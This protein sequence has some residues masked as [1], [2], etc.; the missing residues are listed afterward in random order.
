MEYHIALP[1][2]LGLSSADFVTAWNEAPACRAVAEA[3]LT[4]P[5]GAQFDQALLDMAV[6]V[7]SNV[8]IGIAT[9]AIYDL[10]K[11]VLTKKGVHKRT[12]LMQL[13]QPDG[14]HLL[15]ITTEEK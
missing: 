6:A 14:T 7:L 8:G 15:V 12:Q 9:N 1:P 5:A 2:D 11:Q 13:D 4:S 10:I 3:S